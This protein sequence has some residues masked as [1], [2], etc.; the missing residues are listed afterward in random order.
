MVLIAGLDEAGRGPVIGPLVMAGVL[1]KEE[2]LENLKNIG[3]KDSKL[4][5]P[6]K[7]ERLYDQIIDIAEDHVIII[8]PPKEIDNALN[9]DDM[10]LNWLEAVKSAEIINKLK[11]SKAVVDCPSNNIQAYSNY[12]K[13]RLTVKCDLVVEHKADLNYVESGAASILAKVTRDNEIE[14]LKK[15]CR[16]DFGSGYPSDPKTVKFLKENYDKYN[17]F[18]K[19]WASYKNVIDGKKQKGLDDY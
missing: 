7:R 19:S 10:N 2:K 11:P 12:L 14:K 15:Q 6:L 16:I 1:V 8:V 17:F 13:K 18:R 5:S 4:L 3:V 9:S